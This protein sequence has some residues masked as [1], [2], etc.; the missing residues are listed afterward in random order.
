MTDL[1]PKLAQLLLDT[2]PNG[3]ALS[4]DD[5]LLQWVNASFAQMLEIDPDACTGKSL[6]DIDPDGRLSKHVTF[7]ALSGYGGSAH[8][9]V[10]A[11]KAAKAVLPRAGVLS[12]EAAV[13]R[14]EIE[15]SRSRRYENPLSCLLI[16][17]S[18]TI[19]PPAAAQ[20][21]CFLRE[22]LRWVDVLA[23]WTPTQLLVLLPETTARSATELIRKLAPMAVAVTGEGVTL[24][25]GA[26]TWQLGDD[27]E[28]LVERAAPNATDASRALKSQ[29]RQ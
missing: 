18:V 23:N 5:G 1:H 7:H 4:G 28:R 13:Q 15:M 17:Q 22:Q 21:V 20:L 19:E 27:A 14:L 29:S 6:L 2:V 3:L 9:L 24:E 12:R 16:T 11:P 8:L 10:L 26:S 25:W